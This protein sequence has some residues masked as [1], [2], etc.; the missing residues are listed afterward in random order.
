MIKFDN[1]VQGTYIQEVDGAMDAAPTL[2]T[3]ALH[4]AWRHDMKIKNKSL[5]ISTR[6]L[7]GEENLDRFMAAKLYD[8]ARRTR[9][10][11]N[12][13]IADKLNARADEHRAAYLAARPW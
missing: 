5:S 9:L 7:V 4:S 13:K 12:V 11:G 8:R 10:N 2:Q 1:R 3:R 6:N